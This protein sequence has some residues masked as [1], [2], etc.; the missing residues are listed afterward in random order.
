MTRRPLTISQTATLE[1]IKM[2]TEENGAPPTL[3][4]LAVHLGIASTNGVSQLIDQ[5]EHK[6]YV[7]RRQRVSRGVTVI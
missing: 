4:E 1:A 7:R 2:L 3:R 6:G 5:L